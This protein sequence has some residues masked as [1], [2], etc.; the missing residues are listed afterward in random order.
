MKEKKR[1]LLIFIVAIIAICVSCAKKET[2]V[3]ETKPILLEEKIKSATEKFGIKEKNIKWEKEPIEIRFPKSKL[4]EEFVAELF[5]A[6]NDTEYKVV[7]AMHFTK[8]RPEH[9]SMVFE[10][11]KKDKISLKIILTNEQ[12]ART[13]NVAFLIKNLEK[14]SE[15]NANLLIEFS[16]PLNYIITPWHDKTDSIPQV[17]SRLSGQEVLLEIPIEE[18]KTNELVTRFADRKYTIKLSDNKNTIDGKIKL[19]TSFY[20]NAVGLYAKTGTLILN[21][22][23]NAK[24]FL[25]VLKTKKRNLSFFDDRPK[26][27][28]RNEVCK[29]TANE[30]GVLYGTISISLPSKQNLTSEEWETELMN[31][32]G[33][34]KRNSVILISADDNFVPIFVKKLADIKNKGIEFV[35]ITH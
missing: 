16:E 1:N 21:S 27:L 5:D 10:N 18:N 30:L 9:V 25:Q 33:N 32:I 23:E 4:I 20:P 7:E 26:A 13:T 19:I 15:E 29:E 3:I 24:D 2:P 12:T 14:L 6:T 17:F 34:I 22:K 31:V 28:N 35:P 11:K 8:K